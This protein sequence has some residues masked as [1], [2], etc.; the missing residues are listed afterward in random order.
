MAPGLKRSPI[1]NKERFGFEFNVLIP[2]LADWNDGEGIDIDS[3][4]GANGNYTQAIAYGNLFW[5]EFVEYDDCVFHNH[6]QETTYQSWLIQTQ[7]DKTAVEKVMNHRHL[8]DLFYGQATSAAQLIY[9]GRLLRD[10]WQAKLRR[11][12]P[13]RHIEVEFYENDVSDLEGYQ[14]TFFQLRV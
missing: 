7:G 12:F 10:I 1:F 14:L 8:S 4:L 2:E 9:M 11:D 3:W 5:P 13:G 6:F